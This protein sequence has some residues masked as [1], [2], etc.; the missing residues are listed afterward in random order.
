MS[1]GAFIG[2]GLWSIGGKLRLLKEPFVGRADIEESIAQFVER[3]LGREFLDYAINPFVAGVYAGNP[4]DLS[5]RMAFPKLYRLEE[6]YGGLVKGMIR[7]RKERKRRAEQSKQSAKMFSFVDGMGTFP[8]AL[9]ESIG[10]RLSLNTTVVSL[11]QTGETYSVHTRTPSG[12]R[13]WS[14]ARVVLAVPAFQAAS[15]LGNFY[16]TLSS[17]LTDIHYPPVALVYFGYDRENIPRQLDGFGFLVPEKEKRK[18]LGSIWS[19]VIFPERAPDGCA[20]FTTFVGG[21][22]QPEYADL[23]DDRLIELVHGELSSI[24]GVRE[25]PDFYYIKRWKRAI[26]QYTLGYA[27]VIKRIEKFERT[28]KGLYLCANYR[29]GI[30]VGDCVM[31]ARRTVDAIISEA[32]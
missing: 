11:E 25:Y 19:S 17:T 9:S 6:V 15:I 23:N 7:G 10:S 27:E 3:R 5:V 32:V 18:I 1:P 30:A 31:S 28:Q 29:G 21:S 20:A 24:L 22:R 16:S 13:T 4:E 14:A 8:R 26:P 12:E 2:S